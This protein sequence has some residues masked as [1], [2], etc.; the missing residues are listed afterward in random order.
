MAEEGHLPGPNRHQKQGSLGKQVM[1]LSFGILRHTRFSLSDPDL[2]YGRRSQRAANFASISMEWIGVI[3]TINFT[4]LGIHWYG[5]P[6]SKSECLCAR[7]SILTLADCIGEDNVRERA[8]IQPLW[9]AGT[10]D[11]NGMR[12]ITT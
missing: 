12:S 4:K 10:N 6:S 2:I 1:E 9:L 5:I 7:S 11:V 8:A 3:A